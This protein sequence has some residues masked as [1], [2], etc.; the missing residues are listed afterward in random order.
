MSFFLISEFG[1]EFDYW[2]VPAY[3]IINDLVTSVRQTRRSKAGKY[4]YIIVLDEV[5]IFT[6]F[7]DF[8]SLEL[9][10]DDVDIIIVVNPAS[11]N[12]EQKFNVILQK[13]PT[14]FVRN[15]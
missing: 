13:D 11:V 5:Q 15:S 7:Y 4:N 10:Y 3:K 1:F 8:T 2:N 6:D 9:N 14:P 12:C